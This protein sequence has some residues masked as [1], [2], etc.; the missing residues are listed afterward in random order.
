MNETMPP[1]PETARSRSNVYHLLS[2][3]YLREVI[4]EFLKTLTGAGILEAFDGLGVDMRSILCAEDEGLIKELAEEYAALFV[5]PGGLPPYESVRLKGL[6]SQAPAWEV[7]EFYRKCGLVVR[8]D[9]RF[10]PDHLG[11]ELEFMGYLAGREAEALLKED[12]NSAAEW[13]RFQYD[14]FHNH[15]EKW[16]FAFLQD[17]GRYAFHPFYKSIGALASRFLEEEKEHLTTYKG[18]GETL[19][20]G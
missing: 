16:A 18:G 9:L 8:E 3:L 19:S 12:Q 11:M 6:L 13:R 10:L 5:V 4:P 7:E 17:I 14:F 15:L 1:E 2:G 20:Q